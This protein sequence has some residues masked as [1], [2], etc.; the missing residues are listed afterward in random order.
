MKR[1]SIGTLLALALVLG[2]APEPSSAASA[3]VPHCS[4]APTDCGGWYRTDVTVTWTYDTAGVTQTQGCNVNTVS[5]DTASATFTCTVWYGGPFAGNQVTIKRDA[6]PPQVTGGSP[7]R[8]PDSGD[9]YNRSVPVSFSGSDATSGIAACTSPSYSGPDGA[10]ASVSGTCTDNAGN[11]SAPLSTSLKYD[12]TAPSVT[13][14]PE[15]G[16]DRNGWY[17]A[18]VR[19]TGSGSDGVS[20]VASCTSSSYAGPDS[21]GA[22]VGVT[23]RDNAGNT[24]SPATAVLKYD[25]TAPVVSATAERPPDAKGWYRKPVVVSFSGADAAS[26]IDSCTAP[27]RYE[28]PDGK[29]ARVS[30]SCRD[31]AGNSA[32]ELGFALQY[33][34]TAPKLK[35]VKAEV[36]KGVARLAWDRPAD[37]VSVRIIRSPGV[38]GRR[39]TE[40]FRGTKESFVDRTVRKGVR[41]RYEL[42]TADEAGNVTETTV[43]A[44]P[45]PPLYQPAQGAIVRAPVALAWEAARGA[46]YYN[47]QLYRG[48]VKILSFWP[49][50]PKAKLARTWRFEGKSHTLAP[51]LYRWFVFPANGTPEQPRFGR[52]LGSSSFRVR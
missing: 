27:R 17:S 16:A 3:P 10:S 30:G 39:S 32:G 2:A 45:R 11:V 51:G 24:S 25:A 37:A 21:A 8:S 15:R 49:R 9:W 40:V 28:G 7:S 35:S 1:L 43:T 13:A 23:C 46:R 42:R 52:L 38:N 48:G 14:S 34:A 44:E 33:D 20:G 5:A 26:G 29:T 41:Y 19:V 12:A 47:V 4:P 18:A 22:P 50:T 31:V 36:T 6:T